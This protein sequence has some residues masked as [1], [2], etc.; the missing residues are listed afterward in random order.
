[1][2]QS[3]KR[4]TSRSCKF[5]FP[6][7]EARFSNCEV[8]IALF[9]TVPN[10]DNAITTT[11]TFRGTGVD[12]VAIHILRDQFQLMIIGELMKC[13]N[14]ME[15]TTIPFL[16]VHKIQS[17]GVVRIALFLTVPNFDNAITTTLTFTGTG[18]DSVAIHIL[19]DQFQLMI[20]GEL[21]KCTNMMERATIPFLYVHKIQSV[22]TEARKVL[23][24]VVEGDAPHLIALHVTIE[25]PYCDHGC[26]CFINAI[27][28]PSLSASFVLFL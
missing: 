18:V 22:T 20:N 15:R 25:D 16:Y 11:L 23:R 26:I 24:Q 8:R 1:M 28:S 13:T 6:S 9:L 19:R 4:N 12:S 10:F 5:S 2:I 17:G 14:M 3:N 21:M 7:D 27:C